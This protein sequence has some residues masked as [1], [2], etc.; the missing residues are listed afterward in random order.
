MN[1][2][3][4]RKESSGQ[5]LSPDQP[6]RRGSFVRPF[7]SEVPVWVERYNLLIVGSFVL[8]GTVLAVVWVGRS[9]GPP[10]ELFVALVGMNSA[11]VIALALQAPNAHG[12][13]ERW[14]VTFITGPVA[15]TILSALVGLGVPNSPAG[16]SI[17]SLSVVPAFAGS[18]L[19]LGAV[20]M[21]L[22]AGIASETDAEQ[23][24]ADDKPSLGE[25]S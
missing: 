10:P 16:R 3:I 14:I 9:A 11:L 17:S 6:R 15:I 1:A 12:R 2:G 18:G 19:A 4:P 7:G 20:V 8:S 5:D 23:T 13:F 24:S 21:F 25:S 22:L